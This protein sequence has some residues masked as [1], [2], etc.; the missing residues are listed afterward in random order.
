MF[1]LHVKVIIYLDVSGKIP[2][3]TMPPVRNQGEP[4]EARIVSEFSKEFNVDE[5]YNSESFIG[6][7]KSADDFN[8]VEVPSSC[9][10]NFDEKMLEVCYLAQF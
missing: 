10:L 5:V 9:P 6:S 8:P 7:L 3:Y 2:Y 4:S 1:F